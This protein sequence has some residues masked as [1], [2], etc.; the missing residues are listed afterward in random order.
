M[1]EIRVIVRVPIDIGVFV[2]RIWLLEV[3]GVIGIERK[4]DLVIIIVRK[5]VVGG[6][7]VLYIGWKGIHMVV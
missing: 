1:A 3:F 7:N 5:V 6:L 2:G 4:F